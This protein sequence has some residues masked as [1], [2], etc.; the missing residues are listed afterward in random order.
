MSKSTLAFAA[1]VALTLP[2][3]YAATTS[4]NTG[5]LGAA[6]NGLNADSVTLAA[7]AVA[8][9]GDQ[10][11]AYT[12]VSGSN[13][14]IPFQSSL[15]PGSA[16]PFTIEF[17]ANPSAADNDDSPVSNR[18][19]AGNRS[20]WA[21][22]QRRTTDNPTG[23]NFRMYNGA[24]SATGWDLTG[25]TAILGAWSHVVAT[26]DGSVALLYVNGALAD[27]TNVGGLTNTYNASTSATF[28]VA[29][30]DSGSPYSG[31]VDEVAFYG[32]ALS[33]S[34]IA[35]HFALAGSSTPGAYHS[36]VLTDG[37]R[38]QLSNN[39]VP[40]P[41]AS[42]MIVLGAASLLRRRSRRD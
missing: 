33:S 16:Q 7:G 8:A 26:W 30:T 38:L 42:A 1:S 10:A 11:A 19:S 34:Q 2:A 23:W 17:W 31:L 35:N 3:A 14:T 27:D 4:T 39:P 21:F 28:S 5:S 6:A 13:T 12:G 24:G 9:G 32:I 20:G 37:A 41:G 25:G 29:S 18:V 40:E 36:Q 22:F 15:N